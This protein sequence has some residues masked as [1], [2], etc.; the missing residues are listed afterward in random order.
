MDH[1]KEFFPEVEAMIAVPQNPKFHPE[2][3]VFE[4]TGRRSYG[5]FEY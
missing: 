1:L 4:H 2:G 5:F 3:D